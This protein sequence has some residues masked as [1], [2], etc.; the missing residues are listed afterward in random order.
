[1]TSKI[2]ATSPRTCGGRVP[3][4]PT[5]YSVGPKPKGDSKNATYQ[6][7]GYDL[8]SGYKESFNTV[9]NTLRLMPEGFVYLYDYTE[10]LFHVWKY[11][12][13]T[14]KYTALMSKTGSLEEGIKNYKTK[15]FEKEKSTSMSWSYSCPN[16][17]PSP[18]IHLP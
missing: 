9:Q 4:L 8:E 5:R 16:P 6:D 3:I 14:S 1:M 15:N 13:E 17:P 11:D 12:T 2:S 7:K 10:D 18:Q